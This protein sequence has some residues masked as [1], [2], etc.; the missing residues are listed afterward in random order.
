[1][2]RIEYEPPDQ[3]DTTSAA[4]EN[5]IFA[6]IAAE[7]AALDA[8]NVAEEGLDKRVLES[9]IQS[10]RAFD[11]VRQIIIGTQALAGAGVFA[12]FNAG[13]AMQSAAFTLATNERAVVYFRGQALSDGTQEGVPAAG[14][15]RIRLV[16]KPT[17]GADTPVTHSLRPRSNG[18]ARGG[19]WR[20]ATMIVID[21]P[22]AL[23]YVK[24]QIADLGAG[25][26][27]QMDAVVLHGRIYKRVTV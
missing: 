25:L 1:V 22:L 6:A 20:F 9:E 14:D 8:E 10:T 13:T 2:G 18:T 16:Y 19:P 15:V 11:K 4:D 12:T 27:V 21:G 7:S 17:A 5:A 3:G 24:A 23:D 26:T